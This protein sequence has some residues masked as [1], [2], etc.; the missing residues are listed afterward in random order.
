MNWDDISTVVNNTTQTTNENPLDDVSDKVDLPIVQYFPTYEAGGKIIKEKDINLELNDDQLTMYEDMVFDEG[1]SQTGQLVGSVIS[2]LGTA[3]KS[4]SLLGD[5]LNIS[6]KDVKNAIPKPFR[7]AARIAT[8]LVSAWSGGTVGDLAQSSAQ[9]DLNKNTWSTAL[10][11]AF[12]AGNEEAFYELL[13]HGVTGAFVKTARFIAGKPYMNIQF[14]KD[15]IAES[16]GKLTASQIVDGTILDTVEGLAEVSWGGRHIREQR[17]LNDE[18][19]NRYVNEFQIAFLE[20]ASKTLSDVEYGRL[21][22]KT[23]QA[24]QNQHKAIGGQMFEHLDEVLAARKLKVYDG[25]GNAMMGTTIKVNPADLTKGMVSNLS[26]KNHAKFKL[27]QIEGV[28]GAIDSWEYKY[29]TKILKNADEGGINKLITFGEAQK[30]RS[31]LLEQSRNFADKTHASFSASDLGAAKQLI[32]MIDRQMGDAALRVGGDFYQEYRAANKFWKTGQNRLNNKLVTGIIK[33]NPERVG[34][35]IFATGNVAEIRQ[36]RQALK[37]AEFFA[38]GTDDAFNF[39]K[40]WQTMQQGYLV[41]LVSKSRNVASTELTQGAT[42]NFGKDIA[43]GELDITALKKLFTDPEKMRTFETAFTKGQRVEI[44]NLMQAVEFAQRRPQG[45]GSFMV[46][47]TQGSIVL[48]AGSAG[49]LAGGA[50]GAIAAIG[51]LTLTSSM[52][53]HILTNPKMTSLLAKGLH[54][55]PGN[56]KYAATFAKLANYVGLTPTVEETF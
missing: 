13:G 30:L 41:N 37:S 51:T 45:T 20:G 19:I 55:K 50:P 52:I 56:P 22:Q 42:Q 9:G 24:A 26:I 15:K 12:D 7:V 46:T 23:I 33:Q 6:G 40:T 43:G 18:A 8:Q 2:T 14:I 28:A 21:Y 16:G 44:K 35:K 10:N 53:S 5:T 17:V 25:S 34:A 1:R 4:A 39:N 54:M 47:V 38:K 31:A 49:A 29:Y 32:K 48:A 11:S 27:K 36:A 3:K